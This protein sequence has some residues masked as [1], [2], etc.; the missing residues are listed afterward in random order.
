MWKFPRRGL[1]VWKQ[2]FGIKDNAA[3]VSISLG[4]ETAEPVTQVVGFATH[5]DVAGYVDRDHVGLFVQAIAPPV[6]V[7]TVT[8]TFTATT[9]TSAA[10]AAPILAGKVKLGMMVDTGETPKKT[11]TIT[12]FTD[13]TLTVSAWY[14]QGGAGATG[15][16]P[17]GSRALVNPATKVWATNF[18]VQLDPGSHASGGVGCEAG[19]F[20]YKAPDLGYLYDAVN[21]GT[22]R[23]AGAFQCRGSWITGFYAYAGC[24][25]G[26]VSQAATTH[27]F[28]AQGAH[29]NSFF[30]EGATNAVVLSKG[31]TGQAL[32]VQ[33]ASGA[34]LAYID[35]NGRN[36]RTRGRITYYTAG[37]T[38][39]DFS[40]YCAVA[41]V[42]VAT[43]VNL[44][45]PGGTNA[46]RMLY[47]HNAL[48][49][50]ASVTWA[51]IVESGSGSVVLAP[52]ATRMLISD[53]TAWVG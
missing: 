16:P 14:V 50:T 30:S 12:G 19:L 4:D 2:T 9:V 24:Q 28:Y 39:D 53:N 29:P 44:P 27:A 25:F 42:T 49:S 31:V 37:Q 7:D 3:V 51:G 18:N 46:E 32:L 45:A 17:N 22:Y 21:L 40:F 23:G 5:A 1:K 26:Y 13:T 41:P 36:C 38:I 33:D 6:L 47:L 10:F 11:G 8:T 15:T 52:G 20:N 43:T 48:A 34:N 35:G